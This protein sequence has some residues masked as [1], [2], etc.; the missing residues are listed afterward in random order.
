MRVID[1]VVI[2]NTNLSIA[3]IAWYEVIANQPNAPSRDQIERWKSVHKGV[4]LIFFAN[5]RMFIWR[6]LR[7]DEFQALKRNQQL[8]ANEDLF[9]EKVVMRAV[10]WPKLGIEDLSHC[11]AG[12]ITTLYNVIMQ[13]SLFIPPELAINLVTDL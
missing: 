10:L 8:V 7:R 4:Y 13:G 2:D 12:L 6:Y 9:Q 3:E 1:D 11:E 5:N